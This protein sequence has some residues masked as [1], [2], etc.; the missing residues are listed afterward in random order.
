MP[1]ATHEEV[2]AAYSF[3]RALHVEALG[4]AVLRGD[5]PHAWLVLE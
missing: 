4:E 1:P 3:L 2:A 5:G